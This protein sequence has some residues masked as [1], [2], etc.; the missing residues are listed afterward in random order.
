MTAIYHI[1]HQHN[2]PAI[3]EQGGLQSNSVQARLNLK[4]VNIAHQTIQD[5]RAATRVPLPPGGV[6]H[7]YVP[8]YFAPRSPMLYAIQRGNV[9]GYTEGQTPILHLV[10]SAEAVAASGHPFVFTDGHAIMA[11]THFFNNLNQIDQVD[12][13]IMQARFWADT[14]E[15]NDRLR[16]R[17]A[18]FLVHQ[19][20]P[21]PLVQEIGVL[22]K[23]VAV[24]VKNL[25]KG[26]AH[27]P[28]VALRP[29]WYYH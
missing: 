7:D 18:E 25:L 19:I 20:V 14:Q 24:A 10:V 8:F 17:Q 22:Y 4:H 28:T 1:T 21:W 15:D 11:F 12:W 2:L 26:Q 6:L 9:A 16:R 27:Q 29:E 13:E 5:R 23:E 3:I